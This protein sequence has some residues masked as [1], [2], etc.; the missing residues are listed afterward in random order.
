MR[1]RCWIKSRNS[2]SVLVWDRL[3]SLSSGAQAGK[4]ALHEQRQA[5]HPEPL[6]HQPAQ[7][8]LFGARVS[9]RGARGFGADVIGG[10]RQRKLVFELDQSF[11]DARDA[12]LA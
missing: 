1:R 11:F 7:M 4:P 2:S 8:R 9:G 5:R 6:A 10:E 3:S 12:A